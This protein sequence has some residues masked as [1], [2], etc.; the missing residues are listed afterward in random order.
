MKLTTAFLMCAAALSADSICGKRG[1]L[2]NG[3]EYTVAC[4]DWPL[5]AKYTPMPVPNVPQTQIFVTAPT[6]AAV[7]FRFPDQSQVHELR[8]MANGQLVCAG[9]FDGIEHQEMPEITLL[10]E[11]Q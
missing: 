5:L 9:V 7:R 4:V 8:R 1:L 10:V 3:M 6:G 11:A 2:P